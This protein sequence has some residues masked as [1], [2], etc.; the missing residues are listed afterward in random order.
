MIDYVERYYTEHID[1]VSGIPIPNDWDEFRKLSLRQIDFTLHDE[2]IK[3]VRKLLTVEQYRSDRMAYLATK[4][5]ITDMES[6]YAK[7]FAGMME[8]G[9]LQ[10]E[11][12]GLLAFQYTAPITVLIHFCDREPNRETEI[13]Q[14][15]E[16]HIKRFSQE[17]KRK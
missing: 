11:E 12:P 2:T 13:M 3:R 1:S 17:R 6:R 10:A 4:H 15:I 9:L 8:K 16:A 14:K 7:I 5:F